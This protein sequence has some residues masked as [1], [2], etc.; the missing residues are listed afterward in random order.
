[1][2]SMA[3]SIRRRGMVRFARRNAERRLG[4]L[5]CISSLFRFAME[6][7]P[8]QEWIVFLFLEPIR[9]ARTFFVSRGHVTRRR[10]AERLGLGAFQGNNFLR[11]F[12]LLFCLGRRSGFFFLSL[13]AFLLGEPKERRNRLPDA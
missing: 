4:V 8:L 7:M 10:H 11:H 3:M 6:S 5:G 13:A 9:R 2:A 12:L 1:M